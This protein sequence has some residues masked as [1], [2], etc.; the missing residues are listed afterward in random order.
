ME[1]AWPIILLSEAGA[2]ESTERIETSMLLAEIISE[3]GIRNRTYQVHDRAEVGGEVLE[4]H[5][6]L[7]VL[8]IGAQSLETGD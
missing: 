8:E 3:F 4:V 7:E 2:T 1:N 5:L 6:T